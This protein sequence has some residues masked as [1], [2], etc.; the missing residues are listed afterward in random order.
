M[1]D[2]ELIEKTLEANP[3][4]TIKGKIALLLDTLQENQKTLSLPSLGL[5]I[6]TSLFMRQIKRSL[7]AQDETELAGK[8]RSLREM[9]DSVIGADDGP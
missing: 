4:L 7:E 1:F 2:R 8:V 5:N 9:L 6:P 3:G